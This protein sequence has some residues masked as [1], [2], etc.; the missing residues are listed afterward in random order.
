MPARWV[1]DSIDDGAGHTQV[2]GYWED[3]PDELI[4]WPQEEAAT[5]DEA[6]AA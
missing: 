4:P 2:F 3:A 6:E 1:E 5:A